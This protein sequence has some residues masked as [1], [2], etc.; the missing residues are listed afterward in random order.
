MKWNYEHSIGELH[1]D[2][3]L[4]FWNHPEDVCVQLD[5]WGYRPAEQGYVREGLDVV[6]PRFRGKVS[7]CP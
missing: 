4:W 7:E 2:V 1:P 6:V 3:I 5:D